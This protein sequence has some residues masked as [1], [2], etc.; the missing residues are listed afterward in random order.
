[1][2]KFVPNYR[3]V[4]H[5]CGFGNEAGF[6]NCRNCNFATIASARDIETAQGILPAQELIKPTTLTLPKKIVVIIGFTM[7]LIGAFMGRFGYYP[8]DLI[9]VSIMLAGIAPLWV[10]GITNKGKDVLAK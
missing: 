8:Y 10:M 2:K 5:L 9:G 6:S 7:A 3:W 1:M 4:C